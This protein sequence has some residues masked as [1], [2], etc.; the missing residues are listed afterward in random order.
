LLV[1]YTRNSNRAKTATRRMISIM[2]SL[3]GRN[4]QVLSLTRSL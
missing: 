2:I 1:L 4:V 3:G